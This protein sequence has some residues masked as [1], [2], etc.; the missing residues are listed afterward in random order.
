LKIAILGDTHFG[1]RGDSV[2]FH[3]LYRKFYEEVFFPYL[4]ENNIEI[5][6]QLGDLFDRRK[7]I[8]FQTLALSRKYFFDKLKEYNL[9]FYTLLGNHDILYKNTLEINSPNLLLDSYKQNVALLDKPT[10]LEFDDIEIDVI[11]WICD[12]NENEILEFI[13]QSKNQ[14]CLGHFELAGFEMDKGN[15][16][17]DGMDRMIL[18]KYDMVLSGH[19]HHKSTDGNITYVGTPGEMTWADY[20]DPRGFHIFDTKTRDLDFIENPYKMFHKIVY[21]EKS[22]TLESVTNKDFSQ[23]HNVMVKVVVVNKSNPVLYDMFLDGLYKASPLDV[24]IVEDFTD[25]STISDEDIVDQSDDTLTILD[26][27]IDG[28]E[29]DIEKTK[30][31]T[32]MHKIYFD[33]HHLEEA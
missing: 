22:E 15:V 31:K 30:L 17:Y 16:C 4:K 18:D 24:T 3:N 29:M 10:V 32:L 33:A 8:S 11:P 13:K 19:F 21:D 20:N 28:I 12:D 2:P 27:V 23:Y 1:M 25:Y 14:I 26:K 9:Y 7:F 5:I 6:I